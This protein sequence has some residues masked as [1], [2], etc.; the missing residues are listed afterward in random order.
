MLSTPQEVMEHQPHVTYLH[1]YEPPVFLIDEVHLSFDLHEDHAQV[2]SH[3]RVRHN[4]LSDSKSR[5]F[6]LNGEALILESIKLDDKALSKDRYEVSN[7]L[8]CIYDVPDNFTLDIETKIFPQKNTELSGLYRSNDKFCTQCEAQGFRRITFFPDRP[9]VLAR[10]TVTITADQQAYPCLLSNGNL[11]ETSKLSNGRH[12]AKWEDPFNK[13][14]YL[15]ALVAGDFDVLE[16]QFV[17]QSGREVALKIYVEKGRRHLAQHAMYSLK[18]AMRWD[19]VNYG[20]EYDL[21]TYMI[22]AISDFNMGAMENK[23]LNI[24]NSKYILADAKTA[25]DRDYINILSVVGHEYFHNWTGNRVTC[26]DWFQL[27]LK[28]GLTIF[29]DQS[30]SQDTLSRGVIRI[31]D[32]MLLRERQFPE[33]E[34]PLAHPVRPTSYVAIDNFYT[35]TVYE[36]GS[37]VLRMMQTVLGKAAFRKGMDLYFAQHDGHAVTIEDFVRN[38]EDVSGV[39]LTQFKLW[40]SQAGTP[41]VKVND[42]YDEAKKHYTLNF[43]QYTPPTPGHAEKLPLHIPVNFALLDKNGDE[44]PLSQE[45]ILHLTELEQSFH[46]DNIPCRPVP[47]LLRYFS[48]PVKLQYDY[49]DDDLLFLARYD[50]DDFNGWE[51]GQRYILRVLSRLIKDYQ[52]RLTLKLPAEL[53]EVFHHLL[54]TPTKDEYLLAEKLTIPSEN[55]IGEQMDV[56][57]V[58]AIHAAREFLMTTLALELEPALLAV[59]KR[60]LKDD[61]QTDFDFKRVSRRQLKNTCLTYLGHLPQQQTLVTQQFT[62]ALGKDMADTQA[63]LTILVNMASRDSEKALADFYNEWKHDTLVLDKWFAI[64][65]AAPTPDALPRIKQLAEH[66]AFDFKN[67]NKVYALIGT[68]GRNLITF[69]ALNGEGYVYLREVVQYIDTFNPQIAAKMVSPLAQWRRYNKDRQ[70]LMR[71]QLEILQKSSKLSP[72]LYEMVTKSLG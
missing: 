55:Y 21:D 60:C 65:A 30:F 23:G 14:C 56:I 6:I 12:T 20:R 1:D 44:I 3:M 19:E 62:K 17:T 59:Y 29:R 38:M 31:H 24:F 9:D 10:Y 25:S 13:P 35:A 47:S 11:I 69:H 41:V 36:K 51:A 28:E 46:F 4:R 43:T 53:V 15:F 18:E 40:Y 72:D 71:E 57:D 22:V 63:A 66:E 64:Q 48:A 16:D 54:K 45:S 67:P 49:K 27:S 32:V 34:G 52:Q 50:Q 37:E 58:E 70:A 33:D 39:D 5:D 7:N 61:A 26:R 68:L 8:L 42:H 2:K